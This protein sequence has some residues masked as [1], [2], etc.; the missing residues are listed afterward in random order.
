VPQ[1]TEKTPPASTDRGGNFAAPYLLPHTASTSMTASRP[2]SLT[3]IGIEAA[4]SPD[5]AKA[6]GV[7]L[8]K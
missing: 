4:A 3:F 5:A 8:T 2:S 1:C 6:G 7:A